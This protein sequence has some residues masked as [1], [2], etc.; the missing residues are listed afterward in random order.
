VSGK[1]TAPF[2]YKRKN[3]RMSRVFNFKYSLFF[4]IPAFIFVIFTLNSCNKDSDTDL[5]I[6]KWEIRFVD[7]LPFE[8]FDEG[9]KYLEF[10]ENGNITLTSTETEGS[11]KTLATWTWIEK[12]KK[13][14]LI[15]DGESI[16]FDIIKLDKNN[17][18]FVVTEEG[19]DP[20]TVK[21]IPV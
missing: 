15:V 20:Y 2:I 17:L 5:F 11:I 6:R 16:I 18:W 13:M 4:I 19:E 1:N 10:F 12:D 21:C 9:V 3:K 7:D 8:E 14:M